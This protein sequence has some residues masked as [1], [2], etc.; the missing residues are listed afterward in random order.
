MWLLHFHSI[1]ICHYY[2]HMTC[3]DAALVHALLY[4]F[5]AH[6]MLSI[7]TCTHLYTHHHTHTRTHTHTHTH[8]HTHTH[9][10]INYDAHHSTHYS[11]RLFSHLCAHYVLRTGGKT[12]TKLVTPD[13]K[14]S[15]LFKLV[16]FI[17]GWK[18]SLKGEA[19]FAC[20][21]STS[22]SKQIERCSPV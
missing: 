14:Q 16:S 13:E 3:I 17:T 6:L 18:N 20:A 11:A 19:L 2:A 22:V 4:A 7:I 5:P 21:G 9:S 15:M 8:I 10:C 1:I 12:V